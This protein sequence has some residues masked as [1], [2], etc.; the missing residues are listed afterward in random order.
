VAR[1]TGVFDHRLV[2]RGA[3]LGLVAAVGLGLLGFVNSGPLERELEVLGTFA[4]AL[5]YAT[6]SLLAFLSL[7]GRP[8][9]LLAAIL[10]GLL[11]SFSAF[12]GVTLVLLVP[13]GMWATAYIRLLRLGHR[14]RPLGILAVGLAVGAVL[15]SFF[16]LFLQDDAV[17]W[18][19]DSHG[20]VTQVPD[21]PG[22]GVGVGVGEDEDVVESG[23]TSDVITAAEALLA[24]GLVGAGLLGSVLAP[25]QEARGRDG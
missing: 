4:L 23:C 16:A 9:L 12:S 3:I 8:I 20:Q 13:T 24:M 15:A 6:P 11:A 14:P 2:A 17:C 5:V 10:L 22:P 19:I 7:R 18:K 25:V 1:R 21:Q